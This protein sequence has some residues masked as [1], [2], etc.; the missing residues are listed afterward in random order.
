MEYPKLMYRP[1]AEGHAEEVWG[2]MCNLLTVEDADAEAAALDDGWSLT[3]PSKD[4]P[5]PGKGSDATSE[6]SLLDEPLRV[7]K[8]QLEALTAEEVDALL[9]AERNGKTRKGVIAALEEALE[10]KTAPPPAPPAE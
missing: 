10:A 1:A 8:D 9:T 7:I 5:A 2:V 4:A 6:F 3:P